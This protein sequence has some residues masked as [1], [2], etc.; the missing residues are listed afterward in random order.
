MAAAPHEFMELVTVIAHLVTFQLLHESPK[1]MTFQIL[2][3]LL[4]LL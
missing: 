1:E 3:R 2:L 4:I